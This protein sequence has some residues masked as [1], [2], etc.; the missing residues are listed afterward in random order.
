MAVCKMD[1][2]K[3]LRITPTTN[4][5]SI[6]RTGEQLGNLVLAEGWESYI[7]YSRPGNNSNSQL[8]KIGNKYSIALHL[9]LARCLDMSGY[10]SY[11][12][13]KRL[14]RQIQSIHPSLIHLHNIHSYD[15]N[16]GVLFGFLSDSDIPVVWS[17]HDCWAYTGH[18]THYTKVKCQKWKLLCNNCPQSKEYPKSWFFDGSKRN[19]LKK[20]AL[21]TSVKTMVVVGVSD[22]ITNQLSESFLNKYPIERIYNGIDT[23]IFKPYQSYSKETRDKYNIG[24][25]KVIIGVAASWSE[26]KGLNDYLKLN[27][28]LKGRYK[29]LL[30]GVSDKLKETLPDDIICIRR[31]DSMEDLA[32]LYS[33]A[34]VCL[35]LSAEES[36]GKT[37]AEAL[38]CGVPCIV[39]NS[40]A[41]PELVDNQTGIVVE[42]HDVNGVY[43]AILEIDKWDKNKT[44]SN[45]RERACTLFNMN[46][47]YKSYI[48]LYKKILGLSK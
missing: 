28:F 5:G 26:S 11:F 19:F 47:N 7:A 34:N 43:E 12:A 15:I 2:I 40:T 4:K 30:V 21:F 33:I 32:K 9:L 36:F 18:C 1:K 8:I 37:T 44:E 42:P 35:N 48:N 31:T 41:I 20:K 10:G 38:S 29:I 25:N 24:D 16:L 23:N 46:R 13:T 27:S 6:S 3:I 39:Y 45:C 22:W 14:I 17:Q